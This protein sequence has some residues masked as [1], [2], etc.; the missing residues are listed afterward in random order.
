M[1]TVLLLGVPALAGVLT[2]LML[3][4]RTQRTLEAE[5]A[6]I[7]ADL[8]RL[9]ELTESELRERTAQWGQHYREYYTRSHI[10]EVVREQAENTVKDYGFTPLFMSR[11]ERLIARFQ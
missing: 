2:V 9:G 10:P 3:A 6:R 1:R 4:R 7:D 8:R 5:G 11:A